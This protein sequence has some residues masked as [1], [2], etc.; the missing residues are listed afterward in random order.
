MKA[1]IIT[2]SAL[3]LMAFTVV[4]SLRESQSNQLPPPPAVITEEK[5][6]P[7]PSTG[8]VADVYW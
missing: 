3:A 1:A 7:T 4:W 6:A 2:I 5:T 8:S